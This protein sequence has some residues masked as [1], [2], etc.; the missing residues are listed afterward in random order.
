MAFA[1]RC[2]PTSTIG[3]RKQATSPTTT[4]QSS[5]L[6]APTSM[7]S[8]SKARSPGLS[9][10]STPIT[11]TVPFSNNTRPITSY[12]GR[13]LP[14]GLKRTKPFSSTYETIT[15]ISSMCAESI[16][17]TPEV[18]FFRAI[19]LPITS[20]RTSSASPAISSRIKALTWCSDPEGPKASTSFLIVS[21]IITPPWQ[22]TRARRPHPAS[23]A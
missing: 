16:T 7:Y 14:I 6:E 10:F 21:F 4:G 11:P 20:V 18:P 15:P 3:R 23:A 8:L 19:K 22:F 17:L 12:N 2:P 5:R 9:N 1:V 13:T